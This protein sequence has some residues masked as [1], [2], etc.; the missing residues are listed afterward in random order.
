MENPSTARRRRTCHSSLGGAERDNHLQKEGVGALFFALKHNLNP[1]G[2][3]GRPV[4][5][6]TLLVLV[7]TLMVWYALAWA[8]KRIGTI[9]FYSR[10]TITN[11]IAGALTRI[12]RTRGFLEAANLYE[13]RTRQSG[14]GTWSYS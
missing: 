6:D 2:S 13:I 14:S 8:G 9:T 3:A 5:F 11:A 4:T 1:S 7:L 10:V 12:E